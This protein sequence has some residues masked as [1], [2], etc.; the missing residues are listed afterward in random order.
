MSYTPP[1]VGTLTTCVVSPYTIQRFLRTSPPFSPTSLPNLSVWFDASD[2]TTIVTS[3]FLLWTNKGLSGGIATVA[4]G[5]SVTSGTKSI[6]NLNV[7]SFGIQASMTIPLTLSPVSKTFF[8]VYRMTSTIAT[9]YPGAY[10]YFITAYTSNAF[11]LGLDNTQSAP[12]T[13]LVK[14]EQNFVGYP[15]SALTTVSPSFSKNAVGIIAGRNDATDASKNFIKTNNVG[16]TLSG[17]S[18]ANYVT[19]KL[20]YYIGNRDYTNSFDLAEMIIYNRSLT[21]AEY[22]QVYN[23]LQAKWII[24][25]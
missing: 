6:N 16:L 3:P 25:L 15:V 9:T 24:P 19:S 17:S 14:V 11:G 12:N 20:T 8:V 18:T 21:D 4:N 2:A 22:V 23:Y 13:L 7:M 5:S 10:F 1:P